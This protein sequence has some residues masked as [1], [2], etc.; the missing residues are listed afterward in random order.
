[1]DKVTF[2]ESAVKSSLET[3]LQEALNILNSDD[4]E[5]FEEKK[6]VLI[7]HLR[8]HKELLLVDSLADLAIADKMGQQIKDEF[9]RFGEIT[10]PGSDIILRKAGD[11]DREGYLTLQREYSIMKSMLKDETYCDIAC[12]EHLDPK[13]LM[14]TIIKGET[15]IGYCGIK[16]TAQKSWEIVVEILPQWT[17]KEIGYIAIS[18]MLD[19]IK[20][21][22]GETEFRVRIDPSNH[23][24][25]KLFEKLGAVPNGISEFLIHDQSTLERIEEDNLQYIDEQLIALANKF[26]VEP[27]KLLSHV[28]EYTLPWC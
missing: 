13:A 3:T 14:F 11:A 10:Y 1:M 6:E 16:N 20:T 25:Q 2:A 15:Y 4:G 7:K 27:R 17:R 26:N 8:S 18:V 23:A 21:R 5:S 28:L 24:S 9:W 12:N 22:L 19:A